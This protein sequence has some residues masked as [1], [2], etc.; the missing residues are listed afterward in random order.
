MDKIVEAFKKQFELL[1]PYLDER[2]KRL[3]A[4]AMAK[5]LGHGGIIRISEIT[6]MSEETVRKGVEELGDP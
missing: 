6:E 3:C 2:T 5:Q 4:A 1:E